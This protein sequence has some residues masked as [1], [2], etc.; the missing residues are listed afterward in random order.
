MSDARTVFVTGASSGFGAAIARRFASSGARLVLAARRVER[1][2]AL[3]QELTVPAHVLPLDVTDRA[4][5]ARA[6]GELPREF[7]AIDVLVNNAGG[8]M[9]LEPAQDANLDDW[10]WMVDTN[11]KG[12]MYVTRAVLPGMVLRD[13]GHV[14]NIGSVAGTYPYPGGNVYGATKAFVEQFS[15]NL[16]AD[17]AG[18]R[19]RVTNIEPGMAETE[20]SLVR[21]KGDAAKAGAVYKGFPPLSA[22][23]LAEVVHFCA[24]LPEHVNVN[25]LELMS[26]MQSFAGFSVKRS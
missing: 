6:V 3:A 12:V 8:A 13:R 7:A 26:V 2:E 14:I 19:V 21:F 9:G 22:D 1:L 11:C 16:R 18:K 24:T 23:D 4:A 5:V 10:D 25:R 20:F 15:L 17:L